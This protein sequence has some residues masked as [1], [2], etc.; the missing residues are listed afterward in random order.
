M[1][2]EELIASNPDPRE[3]K[4]AFV[5]QMRI[6]GFY[7]WQSLVFFIFTLLLLLLLL[8]LDKCSVTID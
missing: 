4:R 3:L 8:L 5:V 2:L 1:T 6:Q 7:I